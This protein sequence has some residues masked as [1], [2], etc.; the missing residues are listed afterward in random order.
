MKLLKK[1]A[2]L[3]SAVTIF[4]MSVMAADFTF[5]DVKY[6]AGDETVSVSLYAKS[7]VLSFEGGSSLMITYNTDLTYV[8]ASSSAYSS[9]IELIDDQQTPGQIALNIK[10]DIEDIDT[11]K[12]ICTLTFTVNGDPTGYEFKTKNIVIYDVTADC[13][14]STENISVVVTKD[15]PA[16]PVPG[17]VGEKD[18]YVTVVDDNKA[19]RFVVTDTKTS[20]AA[21]AASVLKATYA[22]ETKQANLYKLL[23]VENAEELGNVTIGSLTV[24]AVLPATVTEASQV[25][26]FSFV[27]VE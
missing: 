24:K 15:A 3:L 11:S 22:G 17:T 6:K 19:T 9:A 12:A 20:V 26:A 14:L 23:G 25:G 2:A 13:D 18:G 1:I 7:N 8:K 27:V 16:D 5:T 4:G 21:T 10:D